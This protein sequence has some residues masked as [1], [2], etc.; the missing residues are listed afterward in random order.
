MGPLTS[1]LSPKRGEEASAFKSGV[2][3]HDLG[4]GETG[5]NL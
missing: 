3:C 1:F 5:E 2:H 4:H